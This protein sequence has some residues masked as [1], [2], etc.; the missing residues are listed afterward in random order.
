MTAGQPV[1]ANGKFDTQTVQA[2]S[3]FQAAHGIPVSGQIDQV[4][5]TE[6]LKL[7][8]TAVSWTTSARASSGR[9]NGPSS[10]HLRAKGYEIPSEL[11][12]G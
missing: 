4:T 2:V 10:A 9:R 11:G 1:T 6:L 12:G 8:P 5:W 3:A 7:E